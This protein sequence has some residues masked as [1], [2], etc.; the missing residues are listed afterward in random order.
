MTPATSKEPS[1]PSTHVEATTPLRTPISSA[2][3]TPGRAEPTSTPLS[4]TT[5]HLVDNGKKELS[6]QETKLKTRREIVALGVQLGKMN[7]ASWASKDEKKKKK[8]KKTHL[9]N[10]KIEWLHGRK[11][12]S[13]SIPQGSQ[14]RHDQMFCKFS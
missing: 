6:E 7:I 13:L 2:L 10:M 1:R 14:F 9:L 12:K 8:K 5:Y 11:L 4:H 3:S